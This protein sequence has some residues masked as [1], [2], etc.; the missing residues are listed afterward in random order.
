MLACL[1]QEGY[2]LEFELQK[3]KQHCQ[4]QVQINVNI[5][6]RDEKNRKKTTASNTRMH[7]FMG[8]DAANK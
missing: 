7:S 5:L 2:C 3:G 6:W 8:F 4:K 1:G